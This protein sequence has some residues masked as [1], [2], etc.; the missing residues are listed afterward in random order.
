MALYDFLKKIKLADE[1]ELSL[2]IPVEEFRKRMEDNVDQSNLILF[3]AFSSNNKP[4]VGT[5]GPQEFYLRRRKRVFGFGNSKA[6]S[7]KGI[8]RKMNKRTLVLVRTGYNETY[9]WLMIAGLSFYTL[10]TGLILCHE[11]KTYGFRVLK[12]CSFVY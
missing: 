8:Y 10:V 2:D 5:V 11:R 4:F 7:A 1:F 12:N 6:V 3:E 9:F